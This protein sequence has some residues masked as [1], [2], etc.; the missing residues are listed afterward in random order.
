[1]GGETGVG[2]EDVKGFC[3]SAP[4]ERVK[5]LDYVPTTRRKKF[6]LHLANNFLA[7]GGRLILGPQ[8]EERGKPEIENEVTRWG[9]PPSGSTCKPHQEC[10]NLIRRLYWFDE[11]AFFKQ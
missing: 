5:E 1:M 8:T 7:G 6:S 2:Y 10:D 11:S 3:K 4:I 9:Y